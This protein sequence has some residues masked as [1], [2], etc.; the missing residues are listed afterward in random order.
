M[1]NYIALIV[2]TAIVVVLMY[3]LHWDYGKREKEYNEYIMRMINE[4]ENKIMCFKC[5]CA[6]EPDGAENQCFPRDR[7]CPKCGR[8]YSGD[9][10]D[11]I[12]SLDDWV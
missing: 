6:C 12:G 2:L 8:R 1:V 3:L 10:G 4:K 5:G 7:V 11:I 9:T